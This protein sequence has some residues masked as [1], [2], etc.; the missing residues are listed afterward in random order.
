M[1]ILKHLGISK[2]YDFDRHSLGALE[3]KTN[4]FRVDNIFNK[5]KY[6]GA[7]ILDVF[8]VIC[9]KDEAFEIN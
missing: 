3:E 2:W 6:I 9:N 5:N 8:A 1:Q 4:Y 7:K